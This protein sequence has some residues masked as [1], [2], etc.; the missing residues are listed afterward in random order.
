MTGVNVFDQRQNA[1]EFQPGPVFANLLLVDEVNR[2]SPKTQAALLECME[3]RQVSVDGVTYPLIE[4]PFMVMATQN[5]IEYEGTYP[6]PEA[7]LD[8]FTMR[9]SL[10]YPPLAE[11]AR[12]LDEQTSKPPLESLAPVADAADV[13]RLVEAARSIYV[14]E[15]VGRYVV[16]LLRQTRND[17]RLYLGA[18]PRAGI[19]LLRVAKSRALS[20]GRDYVTPDDV[21]AVAAPVLA[22]RLIL[23]PEAR[24]AGLGPRRTESRTRSRAHPG[25]GLMTARGRAVLAF[26][27]LCW[28]TAF[29]FG[30]RALYPVAAGL[31]LVVP[32]AVAWVRITL[33]QPRVT[34]RW[35][36][37]DAVWR[38]DDLLER[39]DVRI[40]I[41]LEREPGI[42]LP[43]VVARERIGEFGEREVE[44]QSHSRARNWGSYHLHDVPRGRHRFEPVRLSITDPFGLARARLTLDEQQALVVYPR[45]VELERLFFDGGAGPEHGRRLLL[46]RPV[47]FD[48]H[49][50]RDYQQGESLRRVHWPSTARRGA[51]MVKNIED[52]PRDEVAGPARRRSR[53]AHRLAARLV[54]R[55][56]RPRC[57]LDPPRAG[58]ERAPTTPL[59]RRR[60][61]NGSR[62]PSSSFRCRSGAA[63]FSTD[64]C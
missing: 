2:A 24:S 21:K 41:E 54:L 19:A 50:V 30:S 38:K 20:E 10:G 9:V 7:Q 44:L 46:R 35:R 59:S 14:E 37:E 55:R 60:S 4:P 22:H 11:E 25:S 18:S 40:Q 31:V 56:R 52:S 45:L 57:R 47:G 62:L 43:S 42:P 64:G 6:L 1:F 51:L 61:R 23:A 53:W 5:P 8:R 49:S 3:E 13:L 12:M 16:A 39:D 15:S 36:Q 29:V 33:R 28:I 32:F 34:R 48:L 27:V 63:S 26:G 58:T 17:E